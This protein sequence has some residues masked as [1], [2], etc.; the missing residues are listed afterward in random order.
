MDEN[1][2]K[3]SIVILDDD[4]LSIFLTEE[5][6]REYFGKLH[7]FSFTDP[8]ACIDFLSEQEEQS[9][10]LLDLNMPT[11]EGWVFLDRLKN[12]GMDFQIII[13]T[14]S[15]NN[16]DRLRAVELGVGFLTKP[17]NPEEFKTELS[18]LNTPI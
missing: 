17:L 18:K 2:K 14:S 9:V 1:R 6:I 7:V 15:I 8:D 12:K 10:I 3:S 13:L 16:D 5:I 11:M 4:Q